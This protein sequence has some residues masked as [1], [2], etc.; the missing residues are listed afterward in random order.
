MILTIGF[1]LSAISYT[2]AQRC[3]TTEYYDLRKQNNTAVQARLD[4]VEQI[5]MDWMRNQSKSEFPSISGFTAT[6]NQVTDIQT[7][8]TAKRNLMKVQPEKNPEVKATSENI[9][10]LRIQKRNNNSF[11]ET[12]GGSK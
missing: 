11:V 6:G 9:E 8:A 3:G 4:Y 2:H 5:T 10:K 1:L 12:K 7:Y